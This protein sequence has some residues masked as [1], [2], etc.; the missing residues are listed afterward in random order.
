MNSTEPTQMTALQTPAHAILGAANPIPKAEE[1]PTQI[2]SSAVA[3]VPQPCGYGLPCAKCKT[4]Y[5]ANLTVCPV[6]RSG[7]RVSPVIQE[8]AVA[9]VEEPEPL[10]DPD[11]LE[12]ERERFLREFKSNLQSS[13]MAL[14]TDLE[15]NAS[16]SFRCSREE[17]HEGAFEAASVCQGC[18]DHMR[19]RA[20]QLEAAL[21]LDV[22][23]ATQ[24]IYEAVWAD[25]SDPS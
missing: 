23:E 13:G 19:E 16:E 20:D 2:G 1:L 15:I 8:M 11:V 25:A 22:K 4:Y 10:L 6:C 18:Y 24:I 14:T 5:A 3:A 21:L 7:E 17:N 12:E 9:A